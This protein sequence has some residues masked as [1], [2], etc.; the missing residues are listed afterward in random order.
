[1]D[2]ANFIFILIFEYFPCL[3]GIKTVSRL[4][5]NRH[6]W[7]EYFPCLEGIKTVVSST[8]SKYDWIWILSLF[9]RD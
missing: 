8:L 7:F 5:G 1:M 4:A 2:T 9:R 3:E 6:M